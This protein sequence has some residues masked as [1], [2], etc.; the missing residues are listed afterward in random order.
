MISFFNLMF[1]SLFLIKLFILHLILLFN[2]LTFYE[3]IKKRYFVVLSV[4]PFSKGF[5]LNIY[6]KLL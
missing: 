4:Y 5:L 6:Y 3:Y 1:F 2:G